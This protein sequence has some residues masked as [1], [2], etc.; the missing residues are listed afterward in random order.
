MNLST[1]RFKRSP[2][3]GTPDQVSVLRVR[4]TALL[5]LALLSGMTSDPAFAHGG[6][7]ELEEVVITSTRT[8]RS[9]SQQ[10]TRVE[11]LGAEELNEKANMKPGDIR[12]LLNES[13]GIYVQQTSATSFNSSIRI[14]GLDGKYTQLLRDSLPLYGGFS[15]GLSLLQIAPLDLQQVELLKGANSTLFGGGAIA[16]LVNL[17]S[18]TPGEESERSILLNATSAGGLDLSGFFSGSEGPY[19]ATLFT[20]YNRGEAY[21]PADNGLSAIPEFERWTFNP[22][23]FVESETR[24]FR[25]GINAVTENRLGGDMSFINGNTTQPA[26]FEDSPTTRL[27][28]HLQYSQQLASGKEFVFRNS[29]S[30]FDRQLRVPDFV[31]SGTQLSSFTEAHVLGNSG[32]FDW[33]AGLNV[34]TEDFEQDAVSS[35][36]LDYSTHTVGLFVQGTTSLTDRLTLESGLRV[37]QTS[38]YGSFVLPRIS[39]LYTPS[40]KTT[41]RIGGGLGYKEPTLFTED[42]ERIQYRGLLP[43]KEDGLEA[44]RSSGINVDLNRAFDLGNE[45]SLNLNWL[46]F[47]TRVEDPLRIVQV[48]PDQFAYQQI[49]DYVDSRGTEVNAVFKWE[50]FKLFLGYTHADVREHGV[51]GGAASLVPE[52]RV[53][54]VF[55]YEKENDVRV[56]L[57]AYYYGQQT[58]NDGRTSRDYWIFGLMA[59]KVFSDKFSVFLNFENFT[60]TR[61][62]RYE[63]I[64]TGSITNPLFNDI[65]APLDGF[66]ING[67]FKLSF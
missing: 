17:V 53:N 19:G 28:T 56:G 3:M 14:Q 25:F 64:F 38:D 29:I 33:V 61:Q 60:D 22:T 66:V 4:R 2:L 27:A 65:Y 20:S 36:A 62:S 11:V 13:T 32:E 15:G 9:F 49:N 67:G 10:P 44:E 24:A 21:D 42:A 18:K 35:P 31:F 48:E 39:L 5:M 8:H 7:E 54:T 41:L 57:E 50:S 47:Y 26:Y 1:F 46:L 51:D 59:E 34:W 55:V 58:L 6:A 43:L 63:P 16:G 40:T 23:L 45:L 12:M 52:D 30:H 37:D